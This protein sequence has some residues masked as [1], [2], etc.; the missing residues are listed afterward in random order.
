M[1]R[2]TPVIS[3]QHGRHRMTDKVKATVTV[4]LKRNLG[5][6]ESLGIGVELT[7]EQT[8]AEGQ[9]KSEVLDTLT[10]RLYDSAS[11]HVDAKMNEA[12]TQLKN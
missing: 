7:A 8:V 11:T 5:D 10:N 1:P 2:M 12:Y 4:S 3:F 6:Y 9:L